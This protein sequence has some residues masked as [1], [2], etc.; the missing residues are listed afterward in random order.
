MALE[1]AFSFPLSGGLHARPASRLRDEVA[2]FH[3]VVTFLNRA[4]GAQA[5]ARSVLGLVATLTAFGEPCVLHVQGEDE[6]DAA[7]ALR[8]FVEKEFP[9]LDDAPTTMGSTGGPLPR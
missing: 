5:S 1:I 7:D 3:S 4:S 9:G 2:R 6:S 8:R